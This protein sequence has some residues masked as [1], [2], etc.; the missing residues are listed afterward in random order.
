M[1]YTKVKT[2]VEYR[3]LIE[4]DAND[5]EEEYGNR[6]KYKCKWHMGYCE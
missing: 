1:K 3:L 6:Q 5:D 2:V 4:V